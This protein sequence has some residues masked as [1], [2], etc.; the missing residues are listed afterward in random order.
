MSLVEGLVQN[1]SSLGLIGLIIVSFLEASIFPVPPDVF[2]IPIV[3]VDPSN[4]LLYGLAS[5]LSSAFGAFP[6]YFLGLKL[7]RPIA[8]KLLKP[9]QIDKAEKIYQQYGLLGV[10]IAAFSPIPFKVFTITSGL[11]RLNRLPAFFLVC[12]VGR[13]ARLIPE[14]I[15]VGLWGREA[16]KIVE[17]NIMF[18]SVIGVVIVV[19]TYILYRKLVTRR[20]GEPYQDNSSIS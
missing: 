12:I 3:L 14:A 8:V 17:E 6:G 11:L 20:T 15:L 7:G 2:L 18:F 16:L 5:T 19:A 1:L 4:A 9:S 13:A 10:A